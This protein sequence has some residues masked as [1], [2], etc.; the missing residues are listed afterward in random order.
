[1]IELNLSDTAGTRQVPQLPHAVRHLWAREAALPR[2]PRTSRNGWS[3][4]G[5]GRKSNRRPIRRGSHPGHDPQLPGVS[6]LRPSSCRG[7]WRAWWVVVFLSSVAYMTSQRRRARQLGATL[8][9][10]PRFF[11]AGS[12]RGIWG[13]AGRE[14][15]VHG[16][17]AFALAVGARLRCFQRLEVSERAVPEARPGIAG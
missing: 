9:L 4:W 3:S 16:H 14:G 11:G 8:W 15:G 7:V 1:M 17:R 10:L 2:P 5:G 13:R 6:L 12:R